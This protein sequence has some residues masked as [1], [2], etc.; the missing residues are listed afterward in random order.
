MLA[1]RAMPS[2]P[3][4]SE[5]AARNALHARARR[6]SVGIGAFNDNPGMS[7]LSCNNNPIK[8]ASRPCWG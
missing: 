6:G 7:A 3:V 5:G 1:S 2:M 8:Q 4:C